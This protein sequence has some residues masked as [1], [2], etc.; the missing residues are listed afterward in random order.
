MSLSKDIRLHVTEVFIRKGI[1]AEYGSTLYEA[2]H[3][4]TVLGDQQAEPG[5]KW[6]QPGEPVATGTWK[7]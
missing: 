3:T 1:K 6:P 4:E 5:G 7:K 2:Y